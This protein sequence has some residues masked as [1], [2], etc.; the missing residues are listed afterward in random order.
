MNDFNHD[1][2]PRFMSEEEIVTDMLLYQMSENAKQKLKQ[3]RAVDLI[4]LHRKVGRPLRRFYRLED[5][6]NPYVV[7]TPGEKNFPDEIS[8][9]VIER[10]WSQLTGL[11]IISMPD[12]SDIRIDC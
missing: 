7:M 12:L 8:M 6:T 3:H 10:A 11:P 1:L 9:R 4:S 5:E 2:V